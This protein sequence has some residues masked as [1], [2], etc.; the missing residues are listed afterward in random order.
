MQS[1]QKSGRR[2][3]GIALVYLKLK[4]QVSFQHPAVKSASVSQHVQIIHRIFSTWLMLQ[5]ELMLIG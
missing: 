5:S 4:D 1:C 3:C 2:P